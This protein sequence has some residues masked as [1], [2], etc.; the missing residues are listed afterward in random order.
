[1][2]QNGVYS[3]Y[4]EEGERYAKQHGSAQILQ[5]LHTNHRAKGMRCDSNRFQH[6]EFPSAKG[7]TGRYRIIN[8]GG[9]DQKDQYHKPI[10][11]DIQE[12]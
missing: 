10:E 2:L 6:G 1:M 8:I 7:N 4:D 3:I 11:K 5:K 12:Q 9:A